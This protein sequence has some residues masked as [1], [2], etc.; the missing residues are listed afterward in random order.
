MMSEPLVSVVIP[1]YNGTEYL[2]AAIQSVLDQTYL[3]VEILVVD[4]ASPKDMAGLVKRFA[5]PRLKYLRHDHNQGAVAARHTGVRMAAGEIVAFLDQDDLYHPEKLQAHVAFLQRHP[6]IGATYN[7]RFE[8]RDSAQAVGGLYQPPRRITLADFVLGYPIAPS[9]VVLRREWARREEIWDDSFARAAEHVIFNGQEIVFGGRLAM[10][11]CRFGNVGRALNYRRFDSR[12]RL[13]HLAARCQSELACQELV[14]KDSRCT[15]DIRALRGTA[16]ANIYLMW[17]FAALLQD[18]ADL[19]QEL[20]G[21]AAALQPTLVQ[22]APCQL[23]KTW[24]GWAVHDG[25]ALRGYEA[26]LQAIFDQLPHGLRGLA[27]QRAWAM[28]RAHLWSG[29]YA[30]IWGRGEEAR[31]SLANARRLGASVDEVSARFV[32][33]I[34]LDYE[35]EYGAAATRQILDN[36]RAALVE[37]SIR[38]GA[39]MLNGLYWAN[40]AFHQF[41]AGAYRQVPRSVA[42]TVLADARFLGNRGVLSILFR[43]FAR[44]WGR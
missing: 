20:L 19:G 35:A 26:I 13:R 23:V 17:A 43:S 34:L 9:D 27:E 29:M 3:N 30:T 36:I 7:A 21:R 24:V 42:R 28:T 12:R 32:V 33:G 15:D 8:I 10:A 37:A 44:A 16:A 5:E 4:D 14:F 1:T 2:G 22:G 6:E 41:N 18:E 25:H 39:Q 40:Q 11:G 38:N 31:A